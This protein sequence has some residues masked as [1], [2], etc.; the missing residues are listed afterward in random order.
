M[1]EVT[2]YS[3]KDKRALFLTPFIFDFFFGFLFLSDFPPI[4]ATFWDFF[5]VF[6]LESSIPSSSSSSFNFG[7]SSV[8][9]FSL[10]SFLSSFG[11]S[12]FW[13]KYY[14]YVFVSKW[15]GKNLVCNNLWWIY[16]SKNRD[17]SS[18]VTPFPSSTVGSS[19]GRLSSFNSLSIFAF[20]AI[21]RAL[22]YARIFE[23]LYRIAYTVYQQQSYKPS[24]KW[25]NHSPDFHFFFWIS[26]LISDTCLECLQKSWLFPV[27]AGIGY[28]TPL[29]HSKNAKTLST[30]P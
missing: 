26:F 10:S 16:L 4:S 25:I 28:F 8:E 9:V 13:L 23:K 15:T 24:V 17:A 30:L 20:F 1:A 5:K 22:I 18:E 7:F 12:V 3:S 29:W 2:V 14:F 11:F 6:N 27:H 21:E 19:S